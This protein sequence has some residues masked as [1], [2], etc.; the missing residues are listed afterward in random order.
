MPAMICYLKA[1]FALLLLTANTLFWGIPLVLVSFLKFLL[2]IPAVR[3]FI[4]RILVW[5][6]ENWVG[7][8]AFLFRLLNGEKIEVHGLDKVQPDQW[9]LV[10]SNHQSWVDIPVLQTVFHKKVPFLKFFLKQQLMW[11]PVLGAV[12][13]ALDFPF[14]HRYSKEYLQKHPEKKG[15][16]LEIT[17]KACEKF[18]DFPITII[19]FVEGTRFTPEKH[20][21][22]QSPYRHLL[23]PKAG[24]VGFVLGSLGD[25]IDAVLLVAIRYQPRVPSFVE[26]LCGKVDRIIVTVRVIAVPAEL[27]NRNYITDEDYRQ[28]LQTWLNSLWHNM[29]Q[30][31]GQK[32]GEKP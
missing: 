30:T 29:D 13:W 10:I 4:G 20:Q 21:K 14:M 6:A 27:K 18:R 31:L 23:K 24:G 12:W 28:A 2:P 1:T 26:F 15:K 32:P 8:N 22:Q 3:A 25:Q 9:Y 5:F 17:R 16:D 7:F 19:N 11:V